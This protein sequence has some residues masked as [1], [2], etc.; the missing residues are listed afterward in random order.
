MR[1]MLVLIAIVL[2]SV[3]ASAC[4]GASKGTDSASR[5]SSS[6]TTATETPP[7]TAASGTT[8][9]KR[10]AKT[11]R[12]NDSDNNNDDYGYGHAASATD[13]AAVTAL[14]R[15]YYAAA[16]ADD[17]TTGC[18]LIYSLLAEEIPEVYGE[19]AGPPELRGTT[20]PAVMSKLFKQHHQQLVVDQATLEVIAVRVKHLRALA[21]LSFRTMPQ[22][23]ILVHREHSVWKIDE[24]LDTNLG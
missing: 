12:D 7:V 14:L 2:L 20:C 11:D 24:L 21:M 8:P 4:G 19:G 6:T 15:R 9:V 22:R 13:M 17:G 18:G 10:S 23:G 3:C 5:A 1:S 16:A